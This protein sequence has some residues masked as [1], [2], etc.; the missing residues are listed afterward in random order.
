MLLV[1][2]SEKLLADERVR[3]LDSYTSIILTK[4][5]EQ[6]AEINSKD[7][8][9]R[10]DLKKSLDLKLISQA[11]YDAALIIQAQAT[12][13][14][15]AE[16]N[17]GLAEKTEKTEL[18]KRKAIIDTFQSSLKLAQDVNSAVPKDQIHKPIFQQFKWKQKV[19]QD[20]TIY[21]IGA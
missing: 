14:A 15:I 9:K 19:S 5:E 1:P 7:L 6:I 20:E 8:K 4:E 3:L 18:E 16:I 17:K 10:D 11:E 21:S 13:D 2:I 12:A